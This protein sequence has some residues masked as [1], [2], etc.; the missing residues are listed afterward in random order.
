MIID[1][2]IEVSVGTH[3]WKYYSELGYDIPRN[4]KGSIP[5]G[6]KIKVK[7]EDIYPHSHDKV[8]VRCDFCGGIVNIEYRYYKKKMDK[9]GSIACTNCATEHYKQTM[10]DKYNVDN[11]FQ[12]NE[13]KEKSKKT[14]LQKYGCEYASQSSEIREKIKT[15]NLERYGVE[16]ASQNQE[17]CE[18]MRNTCFERYG[19]YDTFHYDEFIEKSK[20]TCMEKYGCLY[21]MQN[22]EIQEKTK[23][24]N[25][26]RYGVPY[27]S[28]NEEVM[29]KIKQTCMEKYGV[30]NATQSE[31]VKKK[32]KETN[33]IRYG[34]PPTA[35]E[36][37]QEKTKQTNIERYGKEFTL[38]CKEIREKGTRTSLEKYGVPH[39]FQNPDV[40]AK[41]RKTMFEHSNIRASKQQVYIN[42]LYG[43]VLNKPIHHVAV[44]IMLDD[45][46]IEYDGGGHDIQLRLNEVSEDKYISSEK[47]REN[48][49]L[50]QGI[51]IMRIISNNDKI[52]SDDVLLNMKCIAENTLS[53]DHYKICFDVN[54]DYYI[55]DD[56]EV[57]LFDYGKL[58]RIKK[59]DINNKEVTNV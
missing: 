35:T 17:V 46:C 25:M 48:F 43:G 49:I 21:P 15:T 32:I 30:E 23:K 8:K 39:P 58:R 12:T 9:Y 52:P 7:F 57:I 11:Y 31:I 54:T 5:R 19:V 34:G 50:S 6:T 37:V 42:Q 41:A 36:K 3:N 24:T 55:I 22:K 33:N 40:R 44:D 1:K 56:N 14:N 29:E 51:K 38:Q 26:E 27:A 59:D 47:N 10:N 2:E 28:Q 13:C 16:F 20:K 45:F 53:K 4:E 18:K